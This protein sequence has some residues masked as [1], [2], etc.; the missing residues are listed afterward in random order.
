[1][2]V[3]FPV[4]EDRGLES[5]V[6]GH[7]GSARYFVVVDSRSR[8]AQVLANQDAGHQHGSCQPLAALGTPV[9]AVVAGGIGGGA[10]AKLRAAGVRVYRGLEGTVL[11]NLEMIDTGRL[12]EF[13]PEHTCA[14]H[15][16]G[17]PCSH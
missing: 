4:E 11:E 7:F 3:A 1:M 9:D 13:L 12:P 8:T 2:K 6:H 16:P 5:A 10:L 17:E 15:G 14:G